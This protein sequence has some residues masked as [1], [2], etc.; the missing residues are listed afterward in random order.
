MKYHLDSVSTRVKAP[1]A[2]GAQIAFIIGLWW[3]CETAARLCHVPVPGGVLGLLALALFLISGKFPVRWIDKG[4]GKLLDHL[5]LFFVPAAMTLLNH[6]EFLGWMGLKVLAVIGVGVFL[7]MA[8][9]GLAVELHFRM[10]SS[11]VH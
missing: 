11:H 10:R 3:I 6:Q 7:V 5:L 4:A 8:G 1:L 2:T 9:T